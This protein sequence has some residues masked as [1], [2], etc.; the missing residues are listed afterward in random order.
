VRRTIVVVPPDSV[1]EKNL[2]YTMLNSDLP[3]A[4]INDIFYDEDTDLFYLA[5]ATKGL[6]EI[7]VTNSEWR[8]YTMEDGLPSNIVNSVTKADG[9]IWVGTQTGIAGQ[10]TNKTWQAYGKAGGLPG[11][12][13][14]NV[15]SDNGVRL[16]VSFIDAG[17]A[18]VDPASGKGL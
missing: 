18:L 5:L 6:A 13:V 17:V 15:Y 11:H 1:I 7:D 2:Y 4:D 12:I 14:R 8:I 3:E 9:R 16:Y 10:R